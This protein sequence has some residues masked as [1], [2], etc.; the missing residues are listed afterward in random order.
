V[1]RAGEGGRV[2]RCLHV[3]QEMT[4]PYDAWKGEGGGTDEM[5]S[6]AGRT[7]RT[8]AVRKGDNI[9]AHHTPY[10]AHGRVYVQASMIPWYVAR[11]GKTDAKGGGGRG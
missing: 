7:N 8:Y 9:H 6:V 3:H 11:I 10:H 1:L 2:S 4:G 5:Q